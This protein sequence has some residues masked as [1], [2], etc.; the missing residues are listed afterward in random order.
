[1]IHTPQPFT[2]GLLLELR[3]RRTV[4]GGAGERGS[5]ARQL[6]GCCD[7]GRCPGRTPETATAGDRR[8]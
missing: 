5:R 1:M 8:W 4:L 6:H 2:Y 7:P 3:D